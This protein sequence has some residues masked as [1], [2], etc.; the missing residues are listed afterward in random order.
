MT[1]EE[2][3]ESVGLTVDGIRHSL[4]RHTGSRGWPVKDQGGPT[5]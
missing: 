1:I 3:A 4:A 2:A 5:Q